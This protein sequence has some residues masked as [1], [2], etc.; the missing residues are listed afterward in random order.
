MK[1]VSGQRSLD[2]TV[3]FCACACATEQVAVPLE[4][5]SVTVLLMRYDLLSYQSHVV[6]S[7]L[8]PEIIV[9]DLYIW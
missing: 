5:T 7:R 1:Y 8:S 3:I 2:V 4:T 9:T 6:I